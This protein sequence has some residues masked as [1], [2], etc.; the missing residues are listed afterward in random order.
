M[1]TANQIKSE[2]GYTD[3][4]FAGAWFRLTG[5]ALPNNWNDAPQDA[6]F[7]FLAALSTPAK[8][9][10]RELSAKA[11]ELLKNIKVSEPFTER[12]NLPTVTEKEPVQVLEVSQNLSKGLEP[13]Q[14]KPKTYGMAAHSGFVDVFTNLKTSNLDVIFWGSVLMAAFGFV[15]VLGFMGACWAVIYVFSMRQVFQ[16]A[17]NRESQN[18]ARQGLVYVWVMEII[19]FFAHQTMF[20]LASWDAA[21]AGKLPLIIDGNSAAPFIIATVFAAL[22]SLAG[23]YSV[24]VKYRLMIEKIEAEN[25]QLTYQKQY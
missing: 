22:L 12:Q 14:E 17:G 8:G 18:T 25:Y 15:Y 19:S 5:S 24:T 7:S 13:V 1:L 23:V 20:N 11:A 9:R 2:L 4:G 16:M 6:V 3:T 21:S 10:S